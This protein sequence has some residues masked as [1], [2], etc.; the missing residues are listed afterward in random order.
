MS[1]LNRRKCLQGA[2]ALALVPALSACGFTPV[3][4]PGGS[5][6][7]LNGRV[8][9]AAPGDRDSYLLVRALEERLGRGNDPRFALDVTIAT[10][11]EGLAIDAEG[12][13]RRFNLL[14]TADYILRDSRTGGVVTSGQVENFTGYSAT[15]TTVATLAGEQDAQERLMTILAEQI[16]TRLLAADIPA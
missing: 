9:V 7:L 15:G 13:T 5:G 3:Y 16:V 12:N 2:A 1:L 11:E 6:D 4:G 14:G 10:K 8:R